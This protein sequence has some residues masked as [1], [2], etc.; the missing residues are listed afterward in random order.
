M[1]HFV[2]VFLFLLTIAVLL[3][4]KEKGP[5][6]TGRLSSFTWEGWTSS[7]TTPVTCNAVGSLATCAGGNTVD[8]GHVTYSV[9]IVE[10]RD[11]FYAYRTLSWRWQR[12]PRLTEN[13]SIKFAVDRDHL[14]LIDDDGREFKMEIGKKRLNTPAEQLEEC[15]NSVI[16][17][18]QQFPTPDA[19]EDELKKLSGPDLYNTFIS[20]LQCSNVSM[21]LQD[22]GLVTQF[23]AIR[24]AMLTARTDQGAVAGG[25]TAQTE[26]QACQQTIPAALAQ[27]TGFVGYGSIVVVIREENR[28][29]IGADSM[30][31]WSD[32]HP[33][34][35]EC[36]ITPLGDSVIFSAVGSVDAG[37]EKVGVIYS[38]HEIA[39]ETFAK[40]KDLPNTN[41]RTRKMAD[42]WGR[43]VL[44]RMRDAIA[45]HIHFATDADNA[46]MTALFISVPETSKPTT[47]PIYEV[48]VTAKSP[49]ARAGP[50]APAY[51]VQPA[52]IPTGNFRLLGPK[53]RDLVG[54]FVSAQTPRSV[55]ANNKMLTVLRAN[56]TIDSDAFTL[57]AA[58]AALED[59]APNEPIGGKT[60]I[61]ELTR[62]GFDWIA[63]KENC[64]KQ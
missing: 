34:Y 51:I 55:A 21:E 46:I 15:R 44:N 10:G 5:W 27:Y 52:S 56:P 14:T 19:L 40:F 43:V 18:H 45:K 64:R 38:A 58:I 8:W 48:Q 1:K 2:A 3:P 31:T 57:Q 16:E 53:Y 41:S 63:V 13:A 61:L 4:G 6:R 12:S 59:W 24:L 62:S 60:D 49:K 50:Q 26:D 29:L 11:A 30:E 39:K 17:L 37:D 25:S 9:T 35:D 33:T 7:S 22:F 28:I 20:N 47:W 36:K 42:Y 32:K 23:E 54:E